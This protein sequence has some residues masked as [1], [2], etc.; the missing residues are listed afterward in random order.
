L[1]EK[2]KR[3]IQGLQQDLSQKLDANNIS[4]P[5]AEELLKIKTKGV[6]EVKL[7]EAKE[8]LS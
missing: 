5:K 7:A 2:L 8:K 1:R 4:N 6:S 3:D